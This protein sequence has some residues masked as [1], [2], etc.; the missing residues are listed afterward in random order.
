LKLNTIDDGK[1]EAMSATIFVAS[2]AAVI[3]ALGVGLYVWND[4]FRRLP[5]AQFGIDSV[6]RVSAWESSA[7]RERVWA[8]G[9]MT[10]AEWRA[11]NKRQ[12]AAI[13]AELKRRSVASNN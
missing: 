12:I 3:I 9:W 13:D 7:W 8:R 10:S 6:Q 4:R 11:V 5:L 2:L 1:F